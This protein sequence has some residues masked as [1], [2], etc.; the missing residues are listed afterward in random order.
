MHLTSTEAARHCSVSLPTIKQW[1][2]DC[3]LDAI[4]TPGGHWRFEIGAFQR[5]LRRRGLPP[6]PVGPAKTRV[7]IVDDDPS[8]VQMFR[9]FLFDDTGRYEIAD[10]SDGY[11]ALI[12]VGAFK[13]DILLL[14]VMM[15]RVDGIEV[16][17]RLRANPATRHIRILGITGYQE[18]VS[19]LLA[20]GADACLM[21]SVDIQDIRRELERV[22]G[23]VASG[24]GGHEKAPSP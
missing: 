12:Q 1:A 13:P 18:M 23:G 2:R 22:L 5:F 15:P 20:A 21:K 8:I 7:L 16:C 19:P 11:D 3:H 24:G 14:D 10:A 6:Y 4:R 9:D 17:R